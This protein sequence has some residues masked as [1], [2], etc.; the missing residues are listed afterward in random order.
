MTNHGIIN[1]VKNRKKKLLQNSITLLFWSKNTI[2][3]IRKFYVTSDGKK[4]LS[5]KQL[6]NILTLE[7]NSE[8]IKANRYSLLGFCSFL[9]LSFFILFISTYWSKMLYFAFV[10]RQMTK[11][12]NQSLKKKVK[13]LT[14]AHQLNPPA[15]NVKWFPCQWDAMMFKRVSWMAADWLVP[16]QLGVWSLQP[17]V[18]RFVRS[19][20][21]RANEPILIPCTVLAARL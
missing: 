12:T 15:L 13:S 20:L 8:N 17:L 6:N 5:L 1:C 11:N 2:R 19:A 3:L 10:T 14:Q 7:N 18:H 4:E 16:F 9:F 21:R